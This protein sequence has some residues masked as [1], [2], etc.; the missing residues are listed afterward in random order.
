MINYFI[1][2]IYY[3]DNKYYKY[4]KYKQK[5][6]ELKKQNGGFLRFCKPE[7]RI[8]LYNLKEKSYNNKFGNVVKED[9]VNFDK[10]VVKL[11]NGTV[12]TIPKM[13]LLYVPKEK[14]IIFKNSREIVSMFKHLRLDKFES[15]D[16]ESIKKDLIS[17]RKIFYDVLEN[18]ITNSMYIFDEFMFFINKFIN[19][20]NKYVY[21][22]NISP[23]S[24]GSHGQGLKI[25]LSNNKMIHIKIPH[26]PINNTDIMKEYKHLI[27]L[28]H[29]NIMNEIGLISFNDKICK[30]MT[31]GSTNIKSTI[32]KKS[33]PGYVK[34]NLNIIITEYL[35]S[36]LNQLIESAI[37]IDHLEILKL[38]FIMVE[39]I[40]YLYT[41]PKII[42]RDINLNNI[43]VNFTQD[44]D[45]LFKYKIIDFDISIVANES[46]SYEESIY[47][48]T[49]HFAKTTG[50][51]GT[52]LFSPNDEDGDFNIWNSKSDIYSIGVILNKILKVNRVS[53]QVVYSQLS[54]LNANMIEK[55]ISKRFNVYQVY[56]ELNK[57]YNSLDDDEKENV[58]RYLRK[59]YNDEIVY[60]TNKK[61]RIET[62]PI[63]NK[64]L[65]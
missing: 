9:E 58:K 7:T 13:N 23:T 53:N 55:D 60:G 34:L 17:S 25:T 29:P 2:N 38:L 15:L 49:G 62:N 30:I 39:T 31:K 18:F 40:A 46:V 1:Y 59:N 22:L 33:L 65:S 20:T 8:K 48:N 51:S 37:Y 42:H 50:W 12:L 27:K 10:C 41:Y 57:I 28:R 26:S 45:I 63:L 56:E 24:K 43:L 11:D 35:D 16:I 5:Y 19:N 44:P 32:E 61:Y 3:M 4:L 54:T 64:I 6:L 14:S 52:Y 47:G 36:Q 21:I